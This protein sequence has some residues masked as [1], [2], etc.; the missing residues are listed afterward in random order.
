MVHSVNCSVKFSI[1]AGALIVFSL[2]LLM[3]P[4]RWLAAFVCAS[5]VHEVFHGVVI[6]LF[7]GSIR[8]VHVGATGTV[9]YTDVAGGIQEILCAAAGPIASFSLVLLADRFPR[10]AVCGFVHGLYNMLP[11]FPLDGGR[12]LKNILY[13]IFQPNHAGR[14]FCI[15]QL[16][17]CAIILAACVMSAVRIGIA[18][19]FLGILLLRRYREENCLANQ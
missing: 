6:F 17:F 13:V 3:I 2:L 11:L 18:P 9:M 5:V 8:H 10:L 12:I 19:L 7:G 15:I 4:L 1:S 16:C 14:I